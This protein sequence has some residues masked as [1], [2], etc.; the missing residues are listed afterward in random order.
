MQLCDV[1]EWKHQCWTHLYEC[2]LFE[3]DPVKLCARVWDAELAILSRQKEIRSNSAGD[4]REQLAL[5]KAM[6]VL[7]HLRRLLGSRIITLVVDRGFPQHLA[8][9]K[10]ACTEAFVPASESPRE[11]ERREPHGGFVSFFHKQASSGNPA[12]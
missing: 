12:N 1:R 6:D 9:P 5:R 4:V 3:P 7:R 11:V 8:R 2:A 10:R